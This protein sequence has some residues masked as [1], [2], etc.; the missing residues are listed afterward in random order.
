[1]IRSSANP[2]EARARLMGLE[3]SAEILRRALNDP[4]AKAAASLTRMQADAILAMRLQRSTG[5]EADKL[6]AEY[7]DLRGKIAGYERIL[8]DEQLILDLIRGRHARAEGEVRQRPPE[9]DL[10]RGAGRLRQG[11]ADPRGVHGGDRHPRRLHQAAPAQHLPRPEPRRPGDRRHEHPRGRLPRTH[12][13]RPDARL[14][15]VL[16]RPRQGLL[17][18]GL[19]PARG[20]PD[21]RRPGDR[22]PACSS[23]RGRRSPA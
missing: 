4:E 22:Q 15:P 6:A 3:V 2:E 20:H 18:Q 7:A 5:L 23:A 1:M 13:R 8:G 11:K 21:L 10:R 9:R 19:R 12:V 16:H 17:D 14:H